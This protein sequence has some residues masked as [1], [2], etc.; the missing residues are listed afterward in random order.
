MKLKKLQRRINVL[1]GICKNEEYQE[2]VFEKLGCMPADIIVWGKMI[3]QSH[4]VLK[5]FGKESDNG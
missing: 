5:C 1:E 4:T 2:K 3:E